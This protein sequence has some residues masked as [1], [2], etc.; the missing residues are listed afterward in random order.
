MPVIPIAVLM[1]FTVLRYNFLH[2]LLKWLVVILCCERQYIPPMTEQL[3][4]Y[5]SVDLETLRYGH[6]QT[7]QHH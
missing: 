7:R 5:A 6:A 1:L 2:R 3:L 4:P